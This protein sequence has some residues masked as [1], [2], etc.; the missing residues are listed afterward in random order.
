[1]ARGLS[2]CGSWGLECGLN[3]CTGISCSIACGIFPDQGSNLGLLHWQ[4]GSLPLSHREAPG[5]ISSILY[6]IKYRKTFDVIKRDR[7]YIETS[8]NIFLNVSIQTSNSKAQRLLLLFKMSWKPTSLYFHIGGF[9][10][11]VSFLFSNRDPFVTTTW[12]PFSVLCALFAKSRETSTEGEPIALSKKRIN[13]KSQ[14]LWMFRNVIKGFVNE[15][16]FWT[17]IQ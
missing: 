3:S 5:W 13:G 6:I 10:H 9:L 7:S 1:M 16:L 8:T 4:A 17:I 14:N 11:S 12:W 2:N 15:A